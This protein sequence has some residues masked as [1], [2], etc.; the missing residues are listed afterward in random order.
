MFKMIK[1][2]SVMLIV[3][4]NTTIQLNAQGIT[5]GPDIN[6]PAC[7]T[8]T[9][10]H[11]TLTTGIGETGYNMVQ[12]AGGAS[13]GVYT[14]FS[15]SLATGATNSGIVTDDVWSGLINIPFPFYFFGVPQ[16]SCIIGSNGSVSFNG[17]M[18]STYNAWGLTGVA[19]LPNT[20][21]QDAQNSIMSA[22]YDIYPTVGGA[23]LYQTFGTAPNRIFVVSWND[24]PLF[25]CT[26]SLAKQQIALY[27][28]TN[29]IETYIGNK[30]Y[31][32][33]NGGGLAIH[34]IENEGGTVAYTVPGRNV[35]AFTATNETWTF[36]PNGIPTGMPGGYTV[37]WYD[38]NGT[39][40]ATN[41]D[42]LV[43]CPTQPT[44][45]IAS[46]ISSGV[47]PTP[48]F[49]D[50]VMVSKKPAITA[51][52][53]NIVEPNC[54]GGNDGSYE[55]VASGGQP[56]YT[57][58]ANSIPVNN[59]VTNVSAGSYNIVVTDADNCTAT[60]FVTI[61]QPTEVELSL[62][63]QIDV[64]CKYQNNGSVEVLANGGVPGY[65]YWYGSLAP[66][67]NTMF[68]YLAA[69][70]YTF[71]TKDSH[72]CLDSLSTTVLQP[73]SLLSVYQISHEATCLVKTDGSVEAIPSGGVPGYKYEWDSHPPQYSQTATNL[74]S[75]SYHVLVTDA[76]G[77]I[78]STQ[79]AV[80]QQLC[81][82]LFMPDAF[83][84]NGDSKNDIYRIVEH[85]GG[86]ILGEFRIY[87]RWGQ[88]VFSTRDITKGWDGTLNGTSQNSD[89]FHYILQYQCNDKGV[90]SQKIAKGDIILIR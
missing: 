78:T 29:V 30:P 33:W 72:G 10:L 61:N 65:T 59:P 53:Q 13:G 70:N 26:S 1:F 55:I 88:E 18:A 36:T 66:G 67:S 71:Y 32:A 27:E 38:Q 43:V 87:N 25:S 11:A 75:G 58:Q 4:G 51:M 73:D 63:N 83:T 79:I 84:P 39:V 31:C 41:V 64:L 74:E 16:N 2:L 90:I 9:T 76:N 3:L 68:D 5:L 81:C 89:T 46:A 15:L 21:F 8:C 28:T 60:T 37:N 35:Q 50:T 24:V 62:V 17:C 6:I 42:S 12:T 45:I 47:C 48:T 22:Y 44:M 82:Q 23:I 86:V 19:P 52:V 20:T 57:Y 40:L 80:E 14:P 56:A 49:K 69:G 77:C 54:F 7:G 34:G 85:G